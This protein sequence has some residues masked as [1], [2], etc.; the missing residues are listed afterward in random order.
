MKT[1]LVT[2]ANGQLGTCLKD[3]AKSHKNSSFI[4]TNSSE[5]D[6][7]NKNAISTFFSD[8]NID[9]CINCAAY[10]AVDKA[11][12][13]IENATK[14]NVRGAQNLANICKENDT[15]LI[16]ISTDFVFDGEAKTP[17][18]ETDK[19]NP[20]SVYGLTKLKGEEKIQSAMEKY[21]I[22]R[23]SW[24][25]SEYG[26]NFMKTMLR[27]GKKSPK[28]GVVNDQ[29]GTPTYAKDLAEV[30]L[31]F[32][33]ATNLD[34]GIYHYS[35]SGE[36]NWYEFAKE[37]FKRSDISIDLKPIKTIDYPTAAERPKYSILNASKIK[38][39]LDIK[40]PNWKESLEETL[41]NFSKQKQNEK[42]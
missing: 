42:N 36:T 20:K 12:K 2:G 24:L 11:E 25:Y 21:I 23:T 16:H 39:A 17:Y 8:K 7:T 35:N 22:I 14:I 26:V 5:L 41:K 40:I 33:E 27:L 38:K 1:V 6:V 29:K 9:Y 3:V 4:F 31:E 19:P 18:K 13:D 30:I 28:L 10:T 34:F 15:V 37:I 32:I